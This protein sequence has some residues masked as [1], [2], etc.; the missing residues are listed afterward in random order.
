M[1]L[2]RPPRAAH[3]GITTILST[4]ELLLSHY[5]GKGLKTRHQAILSLEEGCWLTT[6][7]LRSPKFGQ[8]WV[9]QTQRGWDL[10]EVW[11]EQPSCPGS[12]G[13]PQPARGGT[14]T[15]RAGA[16]G[17]GAR[18]SESDLPFKHPPCAWCCRGS[19]GHGNAK[20][21]EDALVLACVPQRCYQTR[22]RGTGTSRK[23][24]GS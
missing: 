2:P 24:V 22:P 1:V 4:R 20:P 8:R 23:M 10:P 17:A 15:P 13:A 19:G 5:S 9:G 14:C 7:P 18:E 16:D 6:G 12:S 11:K 3:S 21:M